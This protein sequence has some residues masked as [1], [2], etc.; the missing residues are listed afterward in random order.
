M[1]EQVHSERCANELGYVGRHPHQLSLQP[2]PPRDGSRVV[3]TAE[4]GQVSV[5]DDPELCRQVLDQH[6]HR[7]GGDHDPQKQIAEL[8]AA[9]DVGGEVARIDIRDRG[10]ERRPEHCQRR[11]QTTLGEQLLERAR[12]LR[13]RDRQHT[14][15]GHERRH[16]LYR[17]RQ[18]CSSIVTRIARA[19]TA[20]STCTAS[21]KRTNSGP[22]NVCVAISSNV[23]PGAI[24]RPARN[25]NMARSESDPLTNGP[26][27]PGSSS[28]KLRFST[29]TIS[30]SRSGI[31]SPCGSRVGWPSL[32]AIASSSSSEITCSRRSASASTSSQPMPR[33]SAR[34][35]SSKRC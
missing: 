13:Q 17:R 32:A 3:L 35:S 29:S 9:L 23:L 27:S 2:Q 33:L 20:P 19:K 6:R 31:G 14:G 28:S 11:A 5:G 15:L 21:S 1:E 34:Y 25:R 22:S 10:H 4:L 30:N 26:E 24:P 16:P 18:C 7:V 8:G 12:L